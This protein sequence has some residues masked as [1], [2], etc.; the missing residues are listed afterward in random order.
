VRPSRCMGRSHHGRLVAAPEMPPEIVD[1]D[2]DCWEPLI[3]VADAAGGEWPDR[4][5]CNAVTLVTLNREEREEIR[6]L[7]HAGAARERVTHGRSM[8]AWPEC[9]V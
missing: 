9:P 7:A 2:A 1:R 4:A 3:S 8:G 6:I 5:R